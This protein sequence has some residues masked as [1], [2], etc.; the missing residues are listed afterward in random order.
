VG[1]LTVALTAAENGWHAVYY[2][3]NLPAEEIAAVVKQTGAVA[4]AISITYLLNQHALI[5]ELRIFI[6]RSFR[7]GSA[8]A[9]RRCCILST[10][11]QVSL[12]W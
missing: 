2:G 9:Y 12:L 5:N 6:V 8:H 1:A 7:N 11:A 4:V 10:P 3:P